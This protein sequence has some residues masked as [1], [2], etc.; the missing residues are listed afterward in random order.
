MVKLVEVEITGEL[1][2][3]LYI[4]EGGVSMAHVNDPEPPRYYDWMLWKMRQERKKEEK[5]YIYESPDKGET[6]YRREMGSMKREEIKQ[7][8]QEGIDL[9]REFVDE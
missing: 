5:K 3:F 1:P 4:S 6:I 9:A 8:I 2:N 7:G